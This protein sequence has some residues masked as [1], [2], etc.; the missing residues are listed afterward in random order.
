[1]HEK[2]AIRRK[3]LINRKKNYFEVSSNFFKPLIEFLK[4]QKKNKKILLSFY[5][6]SNYEVNI[7]K[8]FQLIKKMKIKTL[9]PIIKDENT[10]TFLNGKI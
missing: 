10:M 6:P 1:M 5:Y 9:L 4:Q 7:L 2:I 8:L 3:A